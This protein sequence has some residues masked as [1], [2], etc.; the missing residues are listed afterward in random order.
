MKNDEMAYTGQLN[1]ILRIAI[2]L[3]QAQAA[4]L[5]YIETSEINHLVQFISLMTSRKDRSSLDALYIQSSL[6]MTVTLQ[7]QRKVI[8]AERYKKNASE[9]L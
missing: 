6:S 3:E 5:Q 9:Y 7:T 2:Q 8:L 4:A 1:L